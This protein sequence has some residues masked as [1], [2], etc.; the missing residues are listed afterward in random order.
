MNQKKLPMLLL[1]AAG[2]LPFLTCGVPVG[3]EA[4]PE[5]GAAETGSIVFSFGLPSQT[6]N[7]PVSMDSSYYIVEG[8]GP[9]TGNFEVR[10]IPGAAAMVKRVVAGEWRI[11]ANAYNEGDRLI[12]RGYSVVSVAAGE[13]KEARILVFRLE[14]NGRVAFDVLW[15]QSEV[16]DPRVTAV[17]TPESGNEIRLSPRMSS[18]AAHFEEPVPVGYYALSVRLYDGDLHVGGFGEVIRIVKDTTTS[19]TYS[20]PDPESGEGQFVGVIENE[21]MQPIEVGIGNMPIMALEEDETRTLTISLIEDIEVEATWYLDGRNVGEG[22]SYVISGLEPGSYTLTLIVFASDGSRAGSASGRFIVYREDRIAYTLVDLGTGFEL[23][24]YDSLNNRGEVAF[25]GRSGAYVWRDGQRTELGVGRRTGLMSVNDNGQ[26]VGWYVR[27]GVR[28]AFVWEGGVSEDLGTDAFYTGV[29]NDG[30]Y[31]GYR[32]ADYV[33][34]IEKN[35]VRTELFSP[36]HTGIPT[37]INDYDQVSGY[38]FNGTP[39]LWRNGSIVLAWWVDDDGKALDINNKGN[40]TGILRSEGIE[41]TFLWENRGGGVLYDNLAL[42]G[43]TGY[44]INENDLV[45]GTAPVGGGK[46]VGFVIANRSDPADVNDMVESDLTIT[47]L[48]D[49]NDRG[50]IVGYGVDSNGT[51]HVV[52]LDPVAPRHGD[53]GDVAAVR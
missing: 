19:F 36:P 38:F 34:F 44:G 47:H 2:L 45:V 13:R 29:N 40:L 7:P 33:G 21:I 6:I 31:C 1:A 5:S 53:G 25:A 51:R 18:G 42:S 8:D 28:Y 52:L 16:S 32:T 12:G 26:I 48:A 23:A 10:I 9:G 20:F 22:K 39:F 37:G 46:T 35:G 4:V 43:M 3:S 27:D 24:A 49:I 15:S 50:Q 41:R 11:T 14:G 30:T 17:L